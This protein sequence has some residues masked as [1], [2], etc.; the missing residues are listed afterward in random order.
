MN[1]SVYVLKLPR[2]QNPVKRVPYNAIVRSRVLFVVVR[3]RRGACDMATVDFNQAETQT[4][5]IDLEEAR[6]FLVALD[7]NDNTRFRTLDDAK[8]GGVIPRCYPAGEFEQLPDANEKG[9]GVFVIVN[10]TTGDSDKDVISIRAVF[11]DLDGAPLEPVTDCGLTPHVV[12]ES[13]PGRYHA[14]WKVAECPPDKFKPIQQAIAGRFNGD[15]SVVNLSRVMRLPGFIHQKSDPF[16]TRIIFIDGREPYTVQQIVDGLKLAGFFQHDQHKTKQREQSTGDTPNDDYNRRVSWSD[17]LTPNGWTLKQT[18]GDGRELWNKPGHTG[19]QSATV[20]HAGSGLLYCFSDSAGLPVNEG[21]SKYAVY[22]YLQHGGDF[23]AATKELARLGYG[24]TSKNSTGTANGNEGIAGE[25]WPEPIPLPDGLPPVKALDVDLIPAP[26]K[27]WLLDIADRMQI[28]PD[29]ST[30]AA[31]VALGCVIG[32]GCGIHPKKHDDWLVVPNLMGAVIGRPSMMKTPALEQAFKPFDRLEV[33]AK[34]EHGKVMAE[35]EFQTKVEKLNESRLDDEL[36]KAVKDGNAKKIE[37]LRQVHTATEGTPEPARRRYCTSD[38]TPE[39]LCEMANQNPRGFMLK[40]DEL[41]GWL[42]GLDRDGRENA[43]SL[44]LEG[45]NGTGRYAYDTMKHGTIDVE[46]LCFSVFG[47]ITP[48]PLRNYIYQAT[49]GGVGD[50][51]LMQRIQLAV[52]PDAPAQWNLVDRWPDTTAKNQAFEIFKALSCDIPGAVVSDAADIPALRFSPG[53]QDV[54]NTWLAELENRLRKDNTIPPAIESHLAK[55]RSLMP[56]LALI[57]HLVDVADGTTA[58]G[59]VSE[60]A[61]LMAVGYCEYLESH[62]MRIYGGGT[63]PG[64][65]AAQEIIKHFRRGA[66]KD[67]CT[68]KD[69]YRNGWARLTTAEETKAG[70]DILIEYDWLI[71]EK[72]ET[73][74]RPSEIIRL[75]PKGNFL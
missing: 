21:L 27:A 9:A 2:H 74:G 72:V 30:A 16:Q 58:P 46:A 31:F 65:E 71:L 19:Q 41:I 45:W 20:N 73:G 54:F 39:K 44:F 26:L 42:K 36:K 18:T 51:G 13:S 37:E 68:Q 1:Q 55:Y 67:G 4:P 38:G 7:C 57:F 24:Q 32:R 15:K 75:N 59:A 43:R 61:A 11:V 34:E 62:A 29:F 10:E 5:G 64:M 35:Y 23:K 25:A 28:P 53:G 22:T 70:I 50:D 40:R 49:H 33:L 12:V 47:A 6:R 17:V 60:R 63:P 56:S 48:G 14:Y 69:I 66:V 3:R 8:R 52:W